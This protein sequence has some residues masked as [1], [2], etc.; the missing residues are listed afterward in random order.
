MTAPIF[1]DPALRAAV[2]ECQPL[3]D[4]RI[5]S[6]GQICDDIEALEA[7]L[8]RNCA[9]TETT[10]PFGSNAI[11]WCRLDGRWR[12]VFYDAAKAKRIPLFEAPSA[13][14]AQSKPALPVLLRAVTESVSR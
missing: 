9:F 3:I 6:L 2:D 5:R 1:D 8:A 13:V 10:V 4:A 14:L 7:Y 11:T 12:V